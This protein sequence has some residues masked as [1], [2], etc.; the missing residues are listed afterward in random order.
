M[1]LFLS[2][3]GSLYV[4]VRFDHRDDLYVSRLVAIFVIFTLECLVRFIDICLLFYGILR[5]VVEWAV[6]KKSMS[7]SVAEAVMNLYVDVKTSC[8]INNNW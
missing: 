7:E 1:F 4:A 3:I 5:I 2:A 6:Q 8:G